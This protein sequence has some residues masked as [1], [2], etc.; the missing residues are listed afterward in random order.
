MSELAQIW[1]S[2]FKAEFFCCLHCC[3]LQMRQEASHPPQTCSATSWQ[4]T[5]FLFCFTWIQLF[6]YSS[7]KV[8]SSSVCIHVCLC[9]YLCSCAFWST[10]VSMHTYECNYACM[11]IWA[12]RATGQW[13]IEFGRWGMVMGVQ[14]GGGL[15]GDGV[16]RHRVEDGG[17]AYWYEQWQCF[18]SFAPVLWGSATSTSQVRNS[19]TP[20]QQISSCGTGLLPSA[21]FTTMVCWT[22]SA[23]RIPGL[24]IVPQ[25][26]ILWTNT[27]KKVSPPVKAL[28]EHLIWK[29]NH[30]IVNKKL[31]V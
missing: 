16:N 13:G 3:Q 23:A 26:N 20:A 17:G 14:S 28:R 27:I 18:N 15:V 5:P 10:L 9:M 1:L 25:N 21:Y 6:N 12:Q 22:H 2:E 24:G 31:T 8:Q 11:N 29:G 7:D 4:N 19:V 30:L